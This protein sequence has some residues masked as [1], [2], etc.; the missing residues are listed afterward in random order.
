MNSIS[1]VELR[2][3]LIGAYLRVLSQ[4]EKINKINLF[5]VPDQDTGNN[6][7]RTLKGAYDVLEHVS[8]ADLPTLRHEVLEGALTTA[9]GNA[10]IITTSFLGGFLDSFTDDEITP[11]IL[12]QAF[13][14]GSTKAYGSVQEPKVGTILDVMRFTAEKV[15]RL[16]TDVS[17]QSVLESALISAKESLKATESKMDVY[18]KSSVVDAGGLGFTFMLEGFI[19]G[20]TN[21]NLHAPSK[22]VVF[23]KS[24]TLVEIVSQRYEVV[25]LL[26]L[27]KKDKTTI[28]QELIPHGDCIDIVEINNKM[29]IHIHTDHPNTVVD[30]M[31][32]FGTILQMKTVDMNI[33]EDANNTSQSNIGIV[34]DEGAAISLSYATEHDIALVPFQI[35]WDDTEKFPEMKGMNIYEKMRFIRHKSSII[36]FPK[37]SQPSSYLFLKA[38]KDQLQKYQDVICIVTSSAVSGTYNSAL[39]ARNQLSSSQKERVHIPD[40]QQALGGQTLLVQALVDHRYKQYEVQSTIR[41]LT[42]LA[43]EIDVFGFGN[44]AYWLVKGGRLGVNKAKVLTTMLKLGIQPVVG[45]KQGKLGVKGFAKRRD[46]LA[47]MAYKYLIQKYGDTADQYSVVIHHTDSREEVIKLQEKLENTQFSIVDE[48]LLAPILGVHIG[49]DAMVL[50][51]CRSLD[52]N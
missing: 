37:T 47:D 8:F 48:A 49:P 41:H 28:L 27:L 19:H 18:R 38:F 29:K 2:R 5:P 14:H 39:H 36:S 12:I 34:S 44:D 22:T 31:P 23:K 3:M 46:S 21:T 15:Q 16:P 50:A 30:M 10:G 26:E 35:T 6:L 24:K 52:K 11:P 25:S 51:V 13:S 7:V 17:I 42:K 40:L 43:K 1:H 45:V 32:D 33:G 9:A 4:K 20:L